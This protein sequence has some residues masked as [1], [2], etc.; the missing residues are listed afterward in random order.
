MAV[1]TRINLDAS[2]VVVRD[3]TGA[4]QNTASRV[5]TLFEDFDICNSCHA[6]QK[7]MNHWG[8]IYQ[9]TYPKDINKGYCSRCGFLFRP[10]CPDF[11]IHRFKLC[12]DYA[13][14]K[15]CHGQ[16]MRG[17]YLY[18]MERVLASDYLAY[19]HGRGSHQGSDHGGGG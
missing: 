17:R 16:S 11:F 5:G 12:D 1:K 2:S 4:L 15:K 3:E 9:F 10:H 13:L 19:L 7:H 14:C 6:Q 8:S 18:M